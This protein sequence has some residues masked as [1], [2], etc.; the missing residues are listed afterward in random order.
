MNY[1]QLYIP[2]GWRE[3]LARARNIDEL[4]ARVR[5]SR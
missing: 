3:L 4:E 2:K 1:P 5:K